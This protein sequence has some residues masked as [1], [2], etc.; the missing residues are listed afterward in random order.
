MYM[1]VKGFYILILYA[2]LWPLGIPIMK[3]NL[4]W[5]SVGFCQTSKGKKALMVMQDL[6]KNSEEY[7]LMVLLIIFGWH[8]AILWDFQKIA[9]TFEGE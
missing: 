4:A 9:Q 8:E 2:V 6:W 3:S 1:Y 7:F 5:L